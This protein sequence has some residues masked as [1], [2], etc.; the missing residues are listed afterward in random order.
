MTRTELD[1]KIHFA[2]DQILLLGSMVEDAM[3]RSVR[4]LKDHDLDASQAILENDQ[5]INRKRFEIEGVVISSIARQQPMARD[6]RLFASVLDLCAE[7]ERIGDYAKGIAVINLRSGGLSLPKILNDIYYMSEK[8]LNMFHRA[9]TAFIQEDAGV[10]RGI[11]EE[12]DIID[13]LYE[14]IYIEVIDLVTDN[15]MNME[16]GNYV[17]WVAHNL[18]RMADRVTN[19]CE[20]AVYIATGE[21]G[22]ITDTLGHHVRH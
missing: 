14:Q 2:K 7:L 4:A 5:A 12:D 16:R 10:A 20:R 18:E 9:L 1:Q 3:Y 13:A 8:A 19:V 15:P 17:L 22:E 21:L 6:L 11:A